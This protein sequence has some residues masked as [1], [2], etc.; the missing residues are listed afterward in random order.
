MENIINGVFFLLSAIFMAIAIFVAYCFVLFK[1]ADYVINTTN[2]KN[3]GVRSFF[4][5][6]LVIGFMFGMGLS[7]GFNAWI[8]ELFQ[9]LLLLF[10]LPMVIC[11]KVFLFN[12]KN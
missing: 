3:S 9:G 5:S 7:K 12:E 6:C 10:I 8:M 1:L 4:F 2:N 11:L